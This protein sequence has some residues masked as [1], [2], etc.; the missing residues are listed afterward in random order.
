MTHEET[1]DI[2]TQADEFVISDLDTLKVVADP[3][4]LQIIELTF[5]HAHTVKQ[6][7]KKLK[8]P[9]SKLYYHINLL[10]KHGLLAVASTR[11]VSGIV[12]K[13]YQT[14]AHGIRV[15]RGLLSPGR[16]QEPA[17]VG[18]TILVDAILNDAR[19]DIKE[20]AAT[21]LINLSGE[22]HPNSLRISRSTTRFSEEQALAFQARLKA[23]LEEFKQHKD[24]PANAD[25]QRYALV[26]ALYPTARGGRPADETDDDVN[27]A[28]DT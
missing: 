15:E 4:R 11:I 1:T 10:E 27:P 21:G 18:A 2:F 14:S 12:E 16:P 24:D 5:D 26:M 3:L 13:S 23:L 22:E 25:E 9:P 28:A 20:N 8:L 19:N 17:D 7:G 6:I